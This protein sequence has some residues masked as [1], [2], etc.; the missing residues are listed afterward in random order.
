MKKV[1]IMLLCFT[2]S[3]VAA[4]AQNNKQ[5]DPNAGKFKFTEETHDYGEV[6]E[7]PFAECDFV[8][9]NTGNNPIS[10]TEAHGS[11]GCTVPEWPHD[12][13][14]PGANAKIHVKYNTSGRVGPISKDVI[15]NSNAQQSPMVL[16]IRGTVKAKPAGDTQPSGDKVGK[17]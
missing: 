13:I 15:I 2:I 12:P 11:C 14:L 3:G 17:L 4:K 5:A 7:G 16:H 1:I 6:P 8:F 9:T 10:I